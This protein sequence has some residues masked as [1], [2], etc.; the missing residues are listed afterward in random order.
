[1]AQLSKLLPRK[2]FEIKKFGPQPWP[3]PIW[4]HFV[5]H[6]MGIG[7]ICLYTKFEISS[8]TRYKDA[9]QWLDAQGAV[10]KLTRGSPSFF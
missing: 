10:P 5:I 2:G 1:M 9:M 4:G 7:K 8:F 3:H 6:E